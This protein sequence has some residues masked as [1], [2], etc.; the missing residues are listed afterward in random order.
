MRK[1]SDDLLHYNTDVYK[2]QNDG[3]FSIMVEITDEAAAELIEKAGLNTEIDCPIKTVSYTH[4]DVYKRQA[5]NAANLKA[6]LEK[7]GYNVL[8]TES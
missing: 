2:R 4:L 7:S 8:I 1:R 5:Q 3:K 6:A